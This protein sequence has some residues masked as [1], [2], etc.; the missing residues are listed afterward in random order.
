M[1]LKPITAPQAEPLRLGMVK[2]H[3]V[4]MTDD[5]DALLTLYIESARRY[6]ENYTERAFIVQ[7]WELHLSEFSDRIDIPLPPL[8]SVDSVAYLDE[9]GDRQILA[10]SVYQTVSDNNSA[11]ICL[12]HDQSWPAVRAEPGSVI[13]TFTAGYG[14]KPED[15]PANIRTAMLLM[16]GHQYENREAI[17]IGTISSVLPLGVEYHLDQEKVY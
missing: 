7:Q 2:K 4:I 6:A 3:R 15:V 1:T 14:E 10:T 9:N 17:V 13:V 11:Y 12:A 16:V 5:D 8:Q